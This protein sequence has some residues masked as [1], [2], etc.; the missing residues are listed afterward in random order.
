M[1]KIIPRSKKKTVSSL[2]Q[3]KKMIQK[4]MKYS[5][6]CITP[7]S[8]NYGLSKH[9]LVMAAEIILKNREKCSLLEKSQREKIATGIISQA[10]QLK[11]KQ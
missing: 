1:K 4:F 2:D 3:D 10:K 5:S 7:N 8:K 6:D 11:L 9:L